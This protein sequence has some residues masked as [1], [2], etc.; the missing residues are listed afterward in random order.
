MFKK[1]WNVISILLV[2]LLV[3]LAILTVG[4]R[5]I[6]VQPYTV[7][8]GSMSPVYPTGALIY[9]KPAQ[10]QD[11]RVGDPIT[12]YLGNGATVATHRVIDIDTEDGCFYTKGDANEA[13]DGEPV[14]FDHLIGTPV[15]SI[16]LLGYFSNFISTPPGVYIAVAAV[17]A[18]I[19]LIC[20]PGLLHKENEN[21]QVKTMGKNGRSKNGRKAK[22]ISDIHEPHSKALRNCKE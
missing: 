17:M 7:L 4:V 1:V 10:A 9:V 12:F 6:G 16:P 5:L 14:Y 3:V 19:M 11:V 13:A 20:L 18:I 2:C 15:F 21:N 22:P 8:S